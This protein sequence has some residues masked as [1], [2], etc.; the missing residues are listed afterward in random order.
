MTTKKHEVPQELLADYKKPE[1]LIGGNGR[2][3]WDGRPHP[4]RHV[5][6]KVEVLLQPLEPKGSVRH[7]DYDSWD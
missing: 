2:K 3:Q 6:A 5:C 7:G 4:Q 1:D